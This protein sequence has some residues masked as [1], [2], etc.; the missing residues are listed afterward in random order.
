MRRAGTFRLP[1]DWPASEAADRVLLDYDNR[2][3]RRIRLTGEGGTEFLL[4][5][6]EAAALP[7][8]AG[9]SLDDGCWIEVAAAPE[10]VAEITCTG[11][12]LFVRIAWHLG[13]RHLPTEITGEALYIRQD[14]VIEEMAAGLGARVQRLSRPFNPEGGA[15]GGHPTHGHDHGHGHSHSHNHSHSHPDPSGHHNG[16][17]STGDLQTGERP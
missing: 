4:D 6:P 9:L 8:G 14:H 12:D 10:P 15:Y 1:G 11:R 3:R 16:S 2:R 7:H 17:R 5:L 13:N